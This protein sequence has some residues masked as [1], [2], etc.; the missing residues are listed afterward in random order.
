MSAKRLPQQSN[1][2]ML[3][4]I[5]DTET[6][7]LPKNWGAPL[8][9]GENWPRLVQISWIISDG[10]NQEEFNYII[11]PDGF[12]I[13]SQASE[14]HGIT[15]ERAL[16]E[17]N[18]LQFVLEL[19]RA[20]L[21]SADVVVAHNL[22]FDKAIVGAE[23]YRINPALGKAFEEAMS[24]KTIFDTMKQSTAL[25]GLPKSHAGGSKWPKLIELYRHLFNKDFEGAHDALFDTRACA[26]CYFVLREKYAEKN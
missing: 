21:R 8:S 1:K 3:H 13:P 22:D 5:F 11:E 17:G 4:L 18:D 23:Y 24:K 25:V 26:A 7:G 9:D 19:F 15:T 14:I 12:E 6:T 16:A 2:N 10:F 20:L